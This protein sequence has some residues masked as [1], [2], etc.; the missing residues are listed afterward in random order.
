MCWLTLRQAGVARSE[1][2]IQQAHSAQCGMTAVHQQSWDSRSNGWRM[3]QI[4]S[5]MRASSCCGQF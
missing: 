3:C 2:G 4:Q 1:N 5:M